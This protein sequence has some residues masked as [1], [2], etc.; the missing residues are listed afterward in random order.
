MAT[1]TII[2]RQRDR[3]SIISLIQYVFGYES[4]EGITIP[5]YLYYILKN[6]ELDFSLMKQGAGVPYVSGEI[7]GNI[8][9]PIPAV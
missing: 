5:R 7:F 3:Q 4:I 2:T 6:K 9:F 1:G 8:C